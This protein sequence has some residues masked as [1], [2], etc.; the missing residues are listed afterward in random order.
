MSCLAHEPG[1]RPTPAEVAAELEP[2]LDALPALRIS[3]LK[4]RLRR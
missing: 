3:K 1:A 4:P 2:V